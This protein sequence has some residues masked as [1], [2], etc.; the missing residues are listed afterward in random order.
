MSEKA[1]Q[2][3]KIM[4]LHKHINKLLTNASIKEYT[5]IT[6]HQIFLAELRFQL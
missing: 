2:N 5:L 3:Y 6:S 1:R 4:H